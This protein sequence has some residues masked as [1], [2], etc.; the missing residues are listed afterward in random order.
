MR[1]KLRLVTIGT[2]PWHVGICGILIIRA[3]RLRVCG[4]NCERNTERD[5]LARETI[6]GVAALVPPSPAVESQLVDPK[7][8]RRHYDPHDLVSLA[9]QVQHSLFI[10][11]CSC[12][13]N[14]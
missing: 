5:G 9:A 12:Y 10:A 13:D 8:V 6:S 3:A 7:A 2:I 11:L 4:S 1:E 14:P